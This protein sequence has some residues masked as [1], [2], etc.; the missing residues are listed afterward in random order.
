MALGVKNS[1]LDIFHRLRKMR[2]RV[3]I[4][5]VLNRITFTRFGKY[6]SYEHYYLFANDHRMVNYPSRRS[7]VL[8]REA[9]K[10]DIPGLIKML[11]ERG[12]EYEKRMN[13]GDT[14]TIAVYNADIV[15]MEWL[16]RM[17][18]YSIDE[19]P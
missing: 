12:K 4:D 7:N 17:Q 10:E 1:V 9:V 15:G 3:L 8:M 14:A 13:R 16:S 19:K 11:P 18:Q 5:Q 6:F 2:M